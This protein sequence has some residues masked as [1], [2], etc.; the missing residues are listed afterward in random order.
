MKR[1]YNLENQCWQP[2]ES[3]KTW[4]SEQNWQLNNIDRKWQQNDNLKKMSTKLQKSDNKMA[5]KI[6]PEGSGNKMAT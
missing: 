3:D 6:T 2:E 4:I 1:C 5:T